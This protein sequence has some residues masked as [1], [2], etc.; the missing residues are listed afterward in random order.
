VEVF[1]FTPTSRHSVLWHQI[2]ERRFANKPDMSDIFSL[3]FSRLLET[4]NFSL[5]VVANRMMGG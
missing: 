2:E 4:A 5:G 1:R 3:E